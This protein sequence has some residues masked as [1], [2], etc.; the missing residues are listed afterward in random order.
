[1]IDF[2]NYFFLIDI[3]EPAIFYKNILV[4]DIFQL[5]NN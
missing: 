1:M 3:F 4:I 2:E 5:K